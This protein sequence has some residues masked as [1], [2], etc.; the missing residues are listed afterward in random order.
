METWV[1]L[2]FDDG[3][4]KFGFPKVN[5]K[6]MVANAESNI[7]QL[8]VQLPPNVDISVSYQR[9]K[10]QYYSLLN[11][12]RGG[13]K[14]NQVTHVSK[15][16]CDNYAQ[17]LCHHLHQWLHPI[18]LKL[19]QVLPQ[20]CQSDIRLFIHTEKITCLSTKDILHRLPW[21]E[22]SF[23]AQKFFCEAAVCFHS[24][25]TSTTAPE[26]SSTSGKIRRARI[27]SIFGDSTNIDTSADRELLEKLKKR[28]AELIVLKEPNRS[29][30]NA[31]WEEDCD[32][33][34]FAGHSETKGDGQTGIININRNDSLSLAEIKR[35]LK[36]AISKGL[37]LAIF[38]SCDGL[39]L[40]KQ[41]ADLNL[42]YIIVWREEVPD[43]L[44][45]K[46]LQYFL[47]SFSQGES[48]FNSVRQARDKLCELAND[49]DI[50]KRLPG[51]SWL[52]IICK[53]T[54]IPAPNWEDLG[55]LSGEVP[56]CP[57][58]GLSAFRQENADYFFGREKFINKLVKAV[59][60]KPLVPVVGAS[61]SGKSSV[62]FAGLIPRLQATG[63]VE[64]ISFRPG[65]NP[66]DTLAIALSKFLEQR[67]SEA[68]A[69]IASRLA[70]LEFEVNLRHD[71][72]VLCNFIDNI[73]NSSGCK[74]FV[75]VAD[76]FEELYT[77]T[78][79][80]ERYSFLESLLMAVRNV[81]RLTLVLTLR[82][83]F[84]G[85]VLD[86][87]SMGEALQ[88][89]TPL[90][91]TSMNKEEL[92][93]VIEKPALKMKVELKEGLTSKLIN[94]IGNH[95]GRLPLLEF[96]LTQLWSKQKN[97]Y[98]THKAYEEI[99]GLEKALAKHASE[100]L[101]NLSQQQ[102]Q[103]AER[104]FIQL[105]HPGE[106]TE[107]TRRVATRNEIG[108]E[109]W[110]L[111]KCLA[112]ARLLVTGRNEV[113]AEETV[114]IIHEA[115]IWEWGTLR[116]WIEANREFRIWQERLKQEA[117]D[118]KNHNLNPDALLKGRRL[119]VAVDWY[120]EREEQLTQSEQNFI[121][122]SILHEQ[123]EQRQHNRKQKL[124]M[125]GLSGGLVVTLIFAGVAWWQW[126]NARLNEIKAI[127]VSSKAF[128]SLGQ[129]FDALIESLK[130]SKKLNG[131]LSHLVFYQAKERAAIQKEND[132]LLQEALYKT[133]ERNRLQKHK[134][135]IICV[136]FS[137]DGNIIATASKDK[138]VKLW[139]LEGKEI[140]TLTGHTDLVNSVK[141]SPDGKIIAT[142]SWDKTIKLWT[143][144]GKL[145]T[146]LTGHD[147][148][149][150][151]VTFSSDGKT[152]IS[153]DANGYI[154]LW[155]IEGNLI[156]S[157][158]AH[159]QPILNL[160]FS[161]N[162]HIIASA[163]QDKTVKLWSL[164]GKLLR[165]LAGNDGHKDWVWSVNFSPDGQN[166]VTAS[167][168][169]KAKI[170]S[171]DGKLIKNLD[172]HKNSVTSASY[173]PDGKQIVTTSADKT[174]KIWSGFGEELQTL[175]GHQD[176]I[177]SANFSP[178][179]SIIA[180]ASK[181]GT[182][183]LWQIAGKK[184]QI[185]QAHNNNIYSLN[186]SPDGKEIATASKDK[187]VKLHT[188]SGELI[189]TLKAD[190]S[191][192]THVS[193]SPNGQI[194][195]TATNDGKIILW[196]HQGEKIKTFQGHKGKWIWQ[197]SFSPD[198]NTIASAGHDGSIEIRSL[199]GA[200]LKTINAHKQGKYEDGE[201]VNS[202]TFSPDGKIIASASWD[203]TV[204]L[205][206]LEG[207][208]ITTIKKHT[209]GVHSVSF[210]PDGK[211]IATASEDKTVK[212]WTREGKLITTI[213]GHNSGVFRVRFS[214]DGKT[215]ATA[216]LDKTVKLWN[217]EG[218]ELKTYQG[219]DDSILSLNFSPD[220]RTL[221][222]GDHSGKLIL[223]NLDLQPN[224]LLIDG[225]N[226]VRDYLKNNPT[227]NEKE[228]AMC[229]GV[230]M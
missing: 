226:W 1:N 217:L 110:G 154:K 161:H 56:E 24:P 88:Q 168:D 176:W 208:L 36:A 169:E 171:S 119:A 163:S 143:H 124:I 135:E 181:D 160:S 80:S 183:K 57:Y 89:Y 151:S 64:I 44:A 4:F 53:N 8:E 46:F 219:H 9:W 230:G 18:Q 71:E 152:I 66:F 60:S 90:L 35:T 158:K 55:G 95:P 19:E 177:W 164:D 42:P 11:H 172:S 13:F 91:L 198:G 159:E 38:N 72:T 213:K 98:L 179:G 12:S 157:I 61:G 104:I 201:G 6:V 74:R 218:K 148:K 114:E 139:S 76:Q 51:V 27:I 41:L 113:K 185:Y 23:F 81:P 140:T 54:T 112:D 214:P 228:R 153:A 209:D 215:L 186:F 17:G 187:S 77:L 175:K 182:A 199:N 99:G 129:D 93:A 75:L 105:V 79:D 155:N 37:K 26:K 96:A 126:Q 132:V 200:R 166:I 30:F 25:V 40:A 33:L 106:G 94:D 28:S 118:W 210:S 84:L 7:T 63:N 221:A 97:W 188:K 142:A 224:Q 49:K 68:S 108:E 111:V 100:A 147:N 62:V 170:W 87:Q 103:Q 138:T 3:N 20:N 102:K 133:Q 205:W 32:I 120:K 83:D 82:A 196:N 167:R 137:P 229:N 202:V 15:M 73:I 16:N 204:K 192:F 14:N 225:C 134:D 184:Y 227:V 86:N 162:G 222:S 180:T 220:G 109:N 174:V 123:Q 150:Y 144:E 156:K 136:N 149:V 122:A 146:T 101:K 216:S 178:K 189:Q 70:E 2:E 48:L 195:A 85:I 197:V 211:I 5:L 207:K 107:D 173:S 165:T 128:L 65:K 127:S 59:N 206:T 52:P 78:A 193:F 125:F 29:D 34:F 131:T 50:E 67:Q 43:K 121:T 92:R 141:F 194:I 223:W 31:L 203:K 22:W 39:G 212:L 117:R 47:N 10:E 58:Q 116:E 45:Q 130:A 191:Q 145:I 21:Q 190:N 115:L 69:E